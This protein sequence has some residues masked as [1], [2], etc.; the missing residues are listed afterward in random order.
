VFNSVVVVPHHAPAVRARQVLPLPPRGCAH[1]PGSCDTG[2]IEAGKYADLV[3]LD[4]NLFEIESSEISEA[5]A[6][7]TLFEGAVVHGDPAAL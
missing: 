3:V 1:A 5:K 6:V 7:L 2:S 4:R